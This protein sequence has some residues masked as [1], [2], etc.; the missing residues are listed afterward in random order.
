MT[1][2][3]AIEAL[4][5]FLVSCCP[6][7]YK[8]YC[9]VI[10]KDLNIGMA[11]K[12]INKVFKNLIPTYEV[13]LADKIL[14]AD[15][16]LDTPKALKMLPNRIVTQYKIDGYR[17]NIHVTESGEVTICTRNG[18]PVSGYIDLETEASTQT[19]QVLQSLHRKHNL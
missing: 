13:L 7:E 4:S 8:W 1:G 3:A 19:T 15:L 10:E 2:N 11:D 18:K 5:D 9:R 17:L 12:G 16:N 14:P 6:E